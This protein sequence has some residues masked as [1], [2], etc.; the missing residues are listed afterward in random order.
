MSMMS[1]NWQMYREGLHHS[2]SGMFKLN[3][4]V[5]HIDYYFIALYLVAGTSVDHL[6]FKFVLVVLHLTHLKRPSVLRKVNIPDDL[7]FAFKRR[8]AADVSSA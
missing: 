7:A 4:S 2:L 3:Y 8:C 5:I 6:C 1:H